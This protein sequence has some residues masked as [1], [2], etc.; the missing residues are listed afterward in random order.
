MLASVEYSWPEKL[1]YTY[2]AEK[3]FEILLPE[4]SALDLNEAVPRSQRAHLLSGHFPQWQE[5]RKFHDLLANKVLPE[6]QL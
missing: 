1:R 5:R 6:T 2:A 4:L 3:S